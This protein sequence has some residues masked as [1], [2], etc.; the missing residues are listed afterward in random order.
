MRKIQIQVLG[1][2]IPCNNC[3]AAQKNVED[4]VKRVLF[5]DVEFDVVHEDIASKETLEK[6]GL[7]KSP[8]IVAGE[9][10]LFQGMIPNVDKVAKKLA[11]VVALNVSPSKA[12]SSGSSSCGCGCR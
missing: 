7:L 9:Y 2:K 12:P 4:A 1:P 6:F 8:A 10:V 5:P 3:I 11:D